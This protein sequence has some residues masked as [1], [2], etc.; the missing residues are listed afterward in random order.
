MELS[1]LYSAKL[2]ELAANAPDPGRLVAPQGTSRRRARLCGSTIEVDVRVEAG[3]ITEYGHTVRACALGQT[4]AAIV[5]RAAVGTP[6]AELRRVRDDMVAMLRSNGP[7]PEG[8]RWGDLK[9]LEPVRAFPAR[10]DS[11]LL[12]FDALCE[13]LERA[14]AE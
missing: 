12:V 2:L 10:H 6:V 5:A 14:G 3:I 4:S 13:A 11:T 8:A 9:Y 7:P 1:D